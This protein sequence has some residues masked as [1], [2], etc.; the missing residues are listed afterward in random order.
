MVAGGRGGGWE[1]SVI[2]VGAARRGG[3]GGGTVEIG[4]EAS[5]DEDPSSESNEDVRSACRAGN[6]GGRDPEF[7]LFELVGGVMSRPPAPGRGGIKGRGRGGGAGGVPRGDDD[8]SR[9]CCCWS[10]HVF[11]G[12]SEDHE[13]LT[14]CPVVERFVRLVDGLSVKRIPPVVLFLAVGAESCETSW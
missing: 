7:G 1:D 8:D 4:D 2:V 10:R 9:C 12:S 5:D 13:C 3:G 11:S 6:G 14:S